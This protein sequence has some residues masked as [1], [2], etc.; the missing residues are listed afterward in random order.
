MMQ[1]N[2]PGVGMI[3]VL[4][5]LLILAI[6]VLGFVGL[7]LKAIQVAQESTIKTQAIHFMQ[8]ISESMRVNHRG[9]AQY[10]ISLNTY[11]LTDS[12]PSAIQNCNSEL[13]T[14]NEFA[15]F[16]AYD[17]AQQADNFGIG[18]AIATCPGIAMTIA[19]SLKRFCIFSIWAETK[20]AG[21]AN[22][23]DYSA[24][25]TDSGSYVSSSNCL[26]MESY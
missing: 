12:K 1:K 6:A 20:F 15:R 8:S 21:S 23:L 7:Q 16:E 25:M 10:A 9:K 22:A 17:I 24:C 4:V 5:S 3:E 11:A 19:E 18:L 13:C 26:M 2:Q 14:A